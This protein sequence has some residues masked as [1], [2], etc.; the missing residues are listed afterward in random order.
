MVWLFGVIKGRPAK[1]RENTITIILF[2][3]KVFNSACKFCLDSERG[4]WL[5]Y[6]MI[7][8]INVTLMNVFPEQTNL[9][10]EYVHFK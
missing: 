7:L 3:V 6:E 4:M 5:E 10:D 1:K 9:L 8:K 2:Y